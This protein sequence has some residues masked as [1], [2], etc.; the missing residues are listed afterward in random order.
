MSLH[1]PFF[2]YL[3]LWLKKSDLVKIKK[4]EREQFNLMIK[5]SEL[6]QFENVKKYMTTLFTELFIKHCR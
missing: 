3:R 4:R 6:K 1:L 5:V 2:E